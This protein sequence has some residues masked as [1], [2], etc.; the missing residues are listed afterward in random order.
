MRTYSNKT[1]A[2]LIKFGRGGDTVYCGHGVTC[3]GYGSPGNPHAARADEDLTIPDGCPVVD[4]R[5][6]VET[7]DGYRWVFAGPMVDVDLPDGESSECPIPSP[8]LVA[9]VAGNE[10]GSLLAIHE[11]TKQASPRG[12]LD[13]VSIGEYLA[14]WRDHGARVGQYLGGAI[15]WEN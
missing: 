11:A 6:A 12:A 7:A 10:Y 1:T 4:V 8:M 5:A 15:V 2:R 14:G 3:T 13:S 9:G